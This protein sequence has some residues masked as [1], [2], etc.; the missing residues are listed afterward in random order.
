MASVPLCSRRERKLSLSGLAD[1]AGGTTPARALLG[2]RRPVGILAALIVVAGSNA[3]RGPT[4][5]ALWGHA[6]GPGCAR[7]AAAPVCARADAARRARSCRCLAQLA[8][9]VILL[10]FVLRSWRRGGSLSMV[11]PSRRGRRFVTVAC[12]PVLAGPGRRSCSRCECAPVLSRPCGTMMRAGLIRESAPWLAIVRCRRRDPRR[13]LL[14]R[15][16]STAATW[17]VMTAMFVVLKRRYVAARAPRCCCSPRFLGA[18]APLDGRGRPRRSDPRSYVPAPAAAT[19]SAAF[20]P[21][22]RRGIVVEQPH[23]E[24]R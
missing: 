1:V 5:V 11:L 8:A 2:P 20:A 19:R 13:V 15:A 4:P 16:S 12:R 23:D 18:V 3:E 7:S 17:T 6:D 24:R 9:S 10:M 14:G 22:R 21:A